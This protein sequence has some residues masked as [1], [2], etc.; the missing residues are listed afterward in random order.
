MLFDAFPGFGPNR[1]DP[2]R[3]QPVLEQVNGKR[4]QDLRAA[5]REAAPKTPGVY[6]MLDPRNRLTYVGKAK[7]LRAR[8]LSYFRP[9]SRDAK[10]GKIVAQAR[11]VVWETAPSEFAALL[12]ELELIRTFCPSYNVLG[13]PGRRR[14]TY[15]HLG[16]SPAPYFFKHRDLLPKTIA[17]YGPLPGS[18][19]LGDAVRRLNDMFRL[20]DCPQ[21]IPLKF[22][23]QRELFPVNEPAGCLRYDIGMCLGPCIAA[24]TRPQYSRGVRAAKAF[25]DGH[26]LEPL[27]RLKQTM[28][29]AAASHQFER[30]ASLRDRIDD[31]FWLQERLAW[32]QTARREFSFVYPVEGV[33]YVLRGGRVM[34]AVQA[35]KCRRSRKTALRAV[36]SI[37]PVG[38]GS[39]IIPNEMYDHVLLVAAWFRRHADEKQ[40][41]LAP[42]QAREHCRE[43]AAVA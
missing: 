13:Q 2:T 20:R 15:L 9:N 33:W 28:A 19:R 4:P 36:D 37:F 32:L 25:L 30:A 38:G 18:R 31:L 7:N 35:P 14:F 17:T 29:D 12:R 34:A 10:A 27:Q 6:G 24:I 3:S 5:V 39:S 8:L 26:D 42:G 1:Y 21:S 43:P 41:I 23:D 40:R 22:A 16:R 11:A